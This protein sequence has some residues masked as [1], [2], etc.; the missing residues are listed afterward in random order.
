MDSSLSNTKLLKLKA[1]KLK[2]SVFILFP[3]QDPGAKFGFD[4]LFK[5]FHP[6]IN[7]ATLFLSLPLENDKTVFRQ[8]L[9]R[10]QVSKF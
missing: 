3:I 9:Y 5:K 10:F 4:V 2:N 8:I 6:W 7:L 1:T